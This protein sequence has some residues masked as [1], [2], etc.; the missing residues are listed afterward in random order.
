MRSLRH[1]GQAGDSGKL[2]SFSPD[3][4]HCCLAMEPRVA[5]WPLYVYNIDHAARRSSPIESHDDSVM[6]TASAR[7]D[8]GLRPAAA[9]NWAIT[10]LGP[11]ITGSPARDAA[12]SPVA[13]RPGPAGLGGGVLGRWAANWLGTPIRV[14][15]QSGDD[16]RTIDPA[17]GDG[18]L[19]RLLRTLASADSGRPIRRAQASFGA[20]RSAIERAA[21]WL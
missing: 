21:I 17:A 16:M 18:A 20:S 11:C 4:K 14:C 1:T 3:G 7:M 19:A 2:L 9:L 5:P 6:A 15:N 10:H 12:E 8:T 13:C